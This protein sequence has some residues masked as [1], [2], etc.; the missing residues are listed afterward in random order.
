MSA[1]H[2]YAVPSVELECSPGRIDPLLVGGVFLALAFGVLD[3]GAVQVE[4][5]FVLRTVAAALFVL[6]AIS[7]LVRGELRIAPSPLYAPALAFMG[8]AIIQL[9]SGVTAYRHDTLVELLNVGCY[10]VLAFVMLQSLRS[11][12]TDKLTLGISGFGLAVAVFA[13]LQSFASNGKLFWMVQVPTDAF[14]FGPYVNHN[15]YA[16]LMEM[17]IPF[18]LIFTAQRSLSVA[19]RMFFALSAVVMGVSI[20]VSG[21][22]GGVVALGCQVLLLALIGRFTRMKRGA[23]AAL[24]VILMAMAVLLAVVADSAVAARIGTL[25]EPSRADVAGWRMHLNRDSLAMWRARPILGWGL[26]TFPTV[27]PQ[28]RSFYDDVPIHEA[29]N[30]YMQ[31]LAETGA[32]GGLI[33]IW[34]LVAVFR[35]GWRNLSQ[36]RAS[37][38]KGITIA[39]IVSISG[40]LIHSVSDFNLHIP[41][42][43][44]L[45][46]AMCAI[47]AAPV[48]QRTKSSDEKHLGGKG[49]VAP[50]DSPDVEALEGVAEFPQRLRV[51]ARRS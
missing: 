28:F 5:Q 17:L 26:G 19:R 48:T 41:A 39:A 23:A 27:Y 45:F 2:S 21:S 8:L 3:M 31:L 7:Q 38:D 20:V 40:I 15:H 14:F 29:H 16:G 33:T 35:Q 6:W 11:A 24:L 47:A 1:V 46:F 42:N 18:P 37:G 22:R 4:A 50:G 32:I 10:G 25:R 30:D 36:S 44:A 13:L 9:V 51:V 43:A 34:F 49:Y 12:Y